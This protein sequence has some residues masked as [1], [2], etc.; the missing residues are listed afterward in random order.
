MD[1]KSIQY[2]VELKEYVMSNKGKIIIEEGTKNIINIFSDASQNSYGIY[3]EELGITVSKRFLQS[4][5]EWHINIKELYAIKESLNLLITEL[6]KRNSQAKNFNVIS[7]CDNTSARRWIINQK[8][9]S[10][11]IQKIVY[12]IIKYSK[13]FNHYSIFH[14]PGEAN[15]VADILGR[16]MYLLD[17]HLLIQ[18]SF[19]ESE[20][21]VTGRENH[22]EGNLIKEI[23][24]LLKNNQ[25]EIV[26]RNTPVYN[27]NDYINY[28][29]NQ[30]D[31]SNKIK[32]YFP[33]IK[34]ISS[35][36]KIS[37]INKRTFY[38]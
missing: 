27:N 16:E 24:T 35:I 38:M 12:D 18:S 13:V 28:V 6:D 17:N 2:L 7:H 29:F 26:T 22:T 30:F 36:L 33:P 23:R 19:K 4:H 32:I 1:E 34:T 21:E 20:M 9:C 25:V 3:M 15:I 31:T 10:E 8:S 5:L 37:Y 14:I 11:M